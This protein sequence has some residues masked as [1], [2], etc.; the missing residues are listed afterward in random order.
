M[1]LVTSIG[2]EGGAG[3]SEREEW[4]REGEVFLFAAI[5]RAARDDFFAPRSH[6]CRADLVTLNQVTRKSWNIHC[7]RVHWCT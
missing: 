7:T 6:R 4:L 5:E 3:K 1:H 2:S